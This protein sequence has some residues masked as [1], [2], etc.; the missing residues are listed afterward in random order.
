MNANAI[1]FFKYLQIQRQVADIC[2]T[3]NSPSVLSIHAEWYF[4]T[5][6]G[7]KIPP[8]ISSKRKKIVNVSKLITQ[9]IAHAHWQII[10]IYNGNEKRYSFYLVSDLLVMS[11]VICFHFI[12]FFFYFHSSIEF[13]FIKISHRQKNSVGLISLQSEK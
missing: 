3:E 13:H 12:P 7:K 5:E 4:S 2:L 8:I 11:M 1:L 9:S 6:E 10:Y